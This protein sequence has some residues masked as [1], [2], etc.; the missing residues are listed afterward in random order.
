MTDPYKNYEQ[1]R[2]DYAQIKRDVEAAIASSDPTV[3][4]ALNGVRFSLKVLASEIEM[5]KEGEK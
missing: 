4:K 2:P 3:K 1:Y 5:A